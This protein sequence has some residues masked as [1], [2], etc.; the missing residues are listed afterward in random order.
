M[1][2]HGH[3]FDEG[4]LDRLGELFTADVVSDASAFGQEPMHGIEAIRSATLALGDRNSVA[5]H[6]LLGFGDGRA[7]SERPSGPSLP[8]G[9]DR[10]DQQADSGQD[11]SDGGLP[12]FH[13]T[14]QGPQLRR[15]LEAVEDRYDV[16]LLDCRAGTEI[17][18]LACTIAATSIVGAT[19]AGLKEL[20]N[21]IS[22]KDY[23]ADIADGHERSLRLVGIL[24]C[25]VPCRAG[26][27]PRLHRGQ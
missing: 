1:A 13:A 2:L 16:I 20:R 27:R 5:H 10:H 22:L 14:S 17:P 25:A 26:Q 8:I 4:E 21:T 11:Q 6:V 23:V 12:G 18:T 7:G 9:Q 19:Q 3:V 15:A 24:P